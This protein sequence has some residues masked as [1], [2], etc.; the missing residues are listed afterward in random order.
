MKDLGKKS[1]SRH[2]V[3]EEAGGQRID[4]Y[5]VKL[6]KGVPKSHVY[7]ILRS[8][9][10]RVNGGR[11]KP[12]YRGATGDGFRTPPVRPAERLARA[13]PPPSA[14]LEQAVL[15]EDERL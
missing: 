5:L 7:R 12:D 10:V 6:L 9:E 13:A 2:A 15:F 11:A 14:G 8:G 3:D 4:N 1:V